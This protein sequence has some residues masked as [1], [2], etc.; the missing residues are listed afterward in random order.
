VVLGQRRDGGQERG[1]GGAQ[2]VDADQRVALAGLDRRDVADLGLDLAEREPRGVVGH[3]AG[4]GQEAD[5]DV[6]VVADGQAAALEGAHAAA[7]VAGDGVPAGAVGGQ[8]GVGAAARAG[9]EH[10]LAP[11]TDD[12]VPGAGVGH[13]EAHSAFVRRA[14]QCGYVEALDEGSERLGGRVHG[15]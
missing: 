7:H 8:G 5:A 2:A 11:A 4:G 1:L 13:L 15:G 3:A 14:V 12:D 10:R 9:L 6:Q